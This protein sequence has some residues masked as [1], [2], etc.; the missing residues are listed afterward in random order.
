MKMRLFSKKAIRIFL[1]TCLGTI[2]VSSADAQVYNE[3]FDKRFEI[4][5]DNAQEFN[6]YLIDHEHKISYEYKKFILDYFEADSLMRIENLSD[7][8]IKKIDYRLAQ[9]RETPEYDK[10]IPYKAK[11]YEHFSELKEIFDTDVDTL[12]SLKM[13]KRDTPHDL[14]AYVDKMEDVFSRLKSIRKDV[15]DSRKAFHSKYDIFDIQAKF[16]EEKT[17]KVKIEADKINNNEIDIAI[18]N[19]NVERIEEST[20]YYEKIYLSYFKVQ[21]L[22][23][24]FE[25]A[26]DTLDFKQMDYY[27]RAIIH[28]AD[29]EIKKMEQDEGLGDDNSFSKACLK[30]ITHY[31]NTADRVYPKV[32]K[33]AS[34]VSE[35]MEEYE[36]PPY[37]EE[38][39]TKEEI[40]E[41]RLELKKEKRKQESMSEKNREE[42]R[43][44]EIEE[45]KAPIHK[46]LEQA[47]DKERKFVVTMIKA[48][49]KIVAKYQT[50][51]YFS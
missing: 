40:V 1:F 11:V 42:I 9:L 17:T 48:G 51:N 2:A 15:S 4:S 5:F 41:A 29:I 49:F 37:D 19:E 38:G 47:K 25:E 14:I 22:N 24:K 36:N 8:F 39:M 33:A 16:E 27:R 12:F 28:Y 32:I 46:I 45:I 30:T 31:R 20:I 13:K 3:K 26:A 34:S 10:N 23:R 50:Q 21:D 35:M 18:Y 44:E 7:R 43:K 6:D